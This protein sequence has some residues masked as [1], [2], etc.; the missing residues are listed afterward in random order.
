MM[1][2]L[3]AA[4]L[5]LVSLALTGCTL[6]MRDQAR[7]KPLD[8]SDFFPDK[9]SSRPLVEGTIPQGY[10]RRDAYFYEGSRGGVFSDEF[11]LELTPELLKRGRER[12]E[13]YCAVCHGSAGYGDGVAARR[14]VKKPP[15]F[16]ED[17][18]RLQATTG[19]FVQVIAKGFGLMQ[20]YSAEVAP[21]DRWAIA[22]Y[23]RALE[24][25]QNARLGDAPPDVQKKLEAM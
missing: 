16:H 9:M 4:S 12:F 13:I 7:H 18:F 14:G 2:S 3:K 21:R 11:P 1:W 15:S 6:D 25:S 5:V 19:Y 24:L 22:A 23:I 17:R 20:D 10:L 8:E